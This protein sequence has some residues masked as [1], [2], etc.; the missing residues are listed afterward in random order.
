MPSRALLQGKANQRRLPAAQGRLQACPPHFP[1]K[2][3]TRD[4]AFTSA[5]SHLAS[6]SLPKSGR[7]SNPRRSRVIIEVP[8]DRRPLG[9]VGGAPPQWAAL[10]V[11][12]TGYGC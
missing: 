9:E 6:S 8:A 4:S 5:S 3:Q 12:I 2:S 10:R 11:R 1:T 7:C